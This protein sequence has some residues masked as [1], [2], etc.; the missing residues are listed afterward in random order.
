V[1]EAARSRF[2]LQARLG[3]TANNI[4]FPFGTWDDRLIRVLDWA[5]YEI[6]YTTKMGA[7]SAGMNPLALPRVEITGDE[8]P[9]SFCNKLSAYAA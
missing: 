6:G 1:E 5:G 7:V 2:T 9:A 8:T 3:I 4:A